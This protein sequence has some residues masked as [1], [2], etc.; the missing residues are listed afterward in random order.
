[1]SLAQGGRGLAAGLA[2]KSHAVNAIQPRAGFLARAR[3]ELDGLALGVAFAQRSLER[4]DDAVGG[5]DGQ[6]IPLAAL[7]QELLPFVAIFW[8]LR[9]RED[10]GNSGQR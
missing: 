3:L 6:Q 5:F 9:F 1:M 8:L 2:Q 10:I 7:A 4:I